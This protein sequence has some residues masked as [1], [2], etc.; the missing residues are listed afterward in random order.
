MTES[1]IIIIKFEGKSQLTIPTMRAPSYLVFY[2]AIGIV[3]ASD[4][5]VRYAKVM[6]CCGGM[7]GRDRYR[8]PPESRQISTLA[9]RGFLKP[10]NPR[11][12]TRASDKSW[13]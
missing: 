3:W 8:L 5:S 1:L 4:S 7:A 12:S 13:L 10:S 9:S 2:D 6:C 11:L